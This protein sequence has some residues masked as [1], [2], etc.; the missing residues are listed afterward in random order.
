LSAGDVEEGV[1]PRRRRR[2]S[3]TWRSTQTWSS[4]S[5]LAL[6]F[7]S[8]RAARAPLN[9]SRWRGHCSRV[10]GLVFTAARAAVTL[11][12]HR[13]TDVQLRSTCIGHGD[14]CWEEKP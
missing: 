3:I 14:N 10:L 6:V 7:A 9:G 4:S 11:L 8:Q 2:R 5:H 13:R 1:Y 12:F